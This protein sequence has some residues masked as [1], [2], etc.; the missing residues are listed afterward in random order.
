MFAS[1]FACCDVDGRRFVLSDHARPGES[2]E[3]RSQ[4]DRARRRHRPDVDRVAQHGDGRQQSTD[5]GE[6][7]AHSTHADDAAAVRDQ[8]PQDRHAGHRLT[9]RNPLHQPGRPRLESV[10]TAASN[11]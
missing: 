4:V 10:S 2:D 5:A 9:S 3:R 7:R 11:G 8:S 6:Q 1:N